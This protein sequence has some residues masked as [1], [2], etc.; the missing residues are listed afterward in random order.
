MTRSLTGMP[1]DD[2]RNLL[3]TLPPAGEQAGDDWRAR[4][5]QLAKPVGA[6]G[7]LEEI[8]VHL[9]RWQSMAK[10]TV[11]RPL[12]AIFAATHDVAKRAP[13]GLQADDTRATVELI[14]AG[15]AAVNQIALAQNAGLKVFDL[16]LDLPTPDICVEDAL[17]EQ[18]CAATMAFGMES[19]AGGTDLLCVG[20]IGGGNKIV[21][22]AVT[23]ALYGDDIAAWHVPE[24]DG[25]DA[26]S[27]KSLQ[28]KLSASRPD[29]LEIL[30]RFGGRELAAIAGAI[31][32]ARFQK[33]PVLLDGFVACA[34]A[35]VLHRSEPSALDHC[36]AAQSSGGAAH[37]K[38]LKQ[39]DKKPL[40]DL[41]VTL[42]DGTGAALALALIRAASACHSD[43]ATR[44]Q[45][46]T[47]GH[48]SH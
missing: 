21:A 19:I 27:L 32:A 18:A 22:A 29:P 48:A 43:M 8:G 17:S 23:A 42:E 25:L 36:L 14:A 6:L 10:P 35:A 41:G 16:A 28:E 24:L 5:E 26:A 12:L 30:R 2:I 13:A 31:I 1:F 44:D 3:D 46:G 20:A 34:A 37:V 38:L 7:R 39:L 9:A 15:G 11:D 40:L 4:N 47:S 45:A 33:I